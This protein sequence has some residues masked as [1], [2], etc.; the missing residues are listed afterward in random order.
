MPCAERSR[1]LKQRSF[2][3]AAVK[4]DVAHVCCEDS[5]CPNN[6]AWVEAE[7]APAPVRQPGAESRRV[8]Q[9]ERSRYRVKK[10]LSRRTEPKKL[11]PSVWGFGLPHTRAQAGARILGSAAGGQ[12]WAAAAAVCERLSI[13][14]EELPA[15]AAAA[16]AEVAAAALAAGPGGDLGWRE[17]DHRQ[18]QLALPLARRLSY[19]H[20]LRGLP[21]GPR[22]AEAD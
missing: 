16:A 11:L 15:V 22:P 3:P 7:L 14:P 10:S 5:D 9:G 19:P 12:A 20:C 1:V 6:I 18:R 8:S 13:S 17:L 2:F 21:C 4:W